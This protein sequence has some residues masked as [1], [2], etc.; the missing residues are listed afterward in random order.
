MQG[1]ENIHMRIV[2]YLASFVGPI[3]IIVVLVAAIAA[4]TK[5]KADYD[6]RKVC[7]KQTEVPFEKCLDMIN[8]ANGAGM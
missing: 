4:Y 6:P 2:A 7:A 1:K 8:Y 3:L 5:A